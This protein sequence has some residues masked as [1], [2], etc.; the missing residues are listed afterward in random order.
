MKIEFNQDPRPNFPNGVKTKDFETRVA[1][2][3]LCYF[4]GVL[5]KVWDSQLQRGLCGS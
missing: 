4:F 5:T 1:G 3:R 2:L